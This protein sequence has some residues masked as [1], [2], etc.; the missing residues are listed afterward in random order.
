MYQ[1]RTHRYQNRTI[2]GKE[3]RQLQPPNSQPNLQPTIRKEQ[4]IPSANQTHQSLLIKPSQIKPKPM[5]FNFLTT[6]PKTNMHEKHSKDLQ[7][8]PGRNMERK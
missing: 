6:H 5:E 2:D 1:G 3:T 7:P 8:K 4:L